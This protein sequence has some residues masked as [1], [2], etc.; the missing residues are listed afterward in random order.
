MPNYANPVRYARIVPKSHAALAV[1]PLTRPVDLVKLRNAQRREVRE[2]R[3]RIV[4]SRPLG[5]RMRRQGAPSLSPSTTGL[6]HWWTYEGRPI[7]GIGQ[8]LVNVTN[9]NLLITADDLDVPEGGGLDLA[10]RRVYNS[11]SQHDNNND[12]NSTPSV[13]GNKWT[14]N[15]DAHLGWSQIDQNDGTVSVYTGDGGRED[16]TCAINTGAVCTAETP[17]VQDLLAGT[18]LTGGVDCQFQ[19]TKKSG[20]SYIFTAPYQACGKL[21][22][23]YGRLVQIWGRNIAFY[24][25]L[26]YSWSPDA[27][28]PENLH[29]IV[30]TNQASGAQLFLNFGKIANTGITELMSIERPDQTYIDYRYNGTG[31][32]TGVDKPDSDPVLPVSETLPTQWPDGTPIPGGNLPE[33]YDVAQEGLLEA[34]GPRAAIGSLPPNGSPTDGACVDFDYVS[35]S[36]DLAD[37]WT[38]G[39]LNPSPEDDVSYSNIQSGPNTGFAQWD[40]TTFFSND[41]GTACNPLSEAGVSDADKHAISWCYDSSGRVIETAAAVST[42]S[43]LYTSQSWDTNNNLTSETDARGNTTNIA[44]DPNGNAVEIALPQQ[45]V[46]PPGQP[47]RP[48]YLLDYDQHN[49]LTYYCDPANNASNGWNPS[50]SDTL[51]ENSG[52]QSY[53]SYQYY[54]RDISEAYS[55]LLTVTTPRNYHWQYAYAGGAGVCGIGL[56]TTITGDTISQDNGRTPEQSFSYYTSGVSTGL[57]ETFSSTGSPSNASKVSY[58]GNNMNRVRSIQDP[59]GV[60]SYACYNPNGSVFYTETAYQNSLD[61]QNGCPTVN[62]IAGGATPPPFAVGYGYD[63]DGDVATVLRHHGC[64]A[65]NGSNATCT[66]SSPAPSNCY[67]MAVT[68]QTGT[69]CN[70]YDGLGRLVE[71]KQPYDPSDVYK[72]PWITRYLYD[73]S[74]G[75]TQNVFGQTFSAHGNLFEVQE[76]LPAAPTATAPPSPGSVA[77]PDNQPIKAWAYDGLD[78]PVALYAGMASPS[79]GY[80]TETLTWDNTPINSDDVAG[81]LGEDC[82]SASPQQCQEFDYTPDGQLQTFISSD[83]SSPKRVYTYDGDG[84]PTQITSGA[85]SNPQQYAYGPDG[86]IA[87]STDASNGVASQNSATLTYHRY[88]DGKEQSLDVASG[89]FTQAGL[90]GYSYQTDGL[91]KSEAVNDS[92]LG[93]NVKHPGTTTVSYTYTPAGRFSGRSESGADAPNPAPT[94]SVSYLPN[95]GLVKQVNY[96]QTTLTQFTFSVEGE[97]LNLSDS[98]CQEGSIA[99]WYTVRGE[100]SASHLCSTSGGSWF[101]NGLALH[102]PAT[103]AQVTWDNLMAV[104]IGTSSNSQS[105]NSLK[106]TWNYGSD[107]RLK[108]Q[109]APYP[110]WSPPGSVTTTRT[111]DAE[112]H[113]NQTT[114]ESPAPTSNVWPYQQMTWGPDGHPATIGTSQNG[115]PVMNERLHWSGGQL[116]FTVHSGTLDDV[117]VGAQGDILPGDAYSGLT[118]YDRGPGGMVLGCH[119]FTGTSYVGFSGGDW[120]GLGVSPCSKGLNPPSGTKMPAST[121]WAGSPYSAFNAQGPAL[122]AGGTLG[123]L[124]TDGFTDGYDTIQGVRALDSMT[125]LWMTPDADGGDIDD[126]A[127]LKSY[128]WSGNDPLGYVDPSGN[129][130]LYVGVSEVTAGQYHAYGVV[131][132]D[133]A[134]VIAVLSFGPS[135]EFL[136][137]NFNPG[138]YYEMATSQNGANLLEEAQC[139]GTCSWEPGLLSSYRNWPNNLYIYKLP[140]PD[141]NWALTKIFKE[142]GI[143]TTL[144]PGHPSL[145]GWG[146]MQFSYLPGVQTCS[147]VGGPNA[148]CVNFPAEV[149]PAGADTV[150]SSSLDNL[151]SSI[152]GGGNPINV[153]LSCNDAWACMMSY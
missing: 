91:L 134:N 110:I 136:N 27:S 19:W 73:L 33:T 65:T 105:T 113:L 121:L 13:F 95:L 59:D 141:S 138:V 22:G 104:L 84:R 92:S 153:P 17:G 123:T 39:V 125:G 124:R 5:R 1:E 16:F 112:N 60:T 50:Q 132:D 120:L 151:M 139:S 72:S 90:F 83:G 152:Y 77:N 126:P 40:D 146:W 122:G 8:A 14:N 32:L 127:S 29:Q 97:L 46:T 106:S 78:R 79:P 88:P 69:T 103:G 20:V 99:Y 51:C 52:S 140:S 26:S 117:K 21:P 135:G 82:N 137:N 131:T 25:T 94:A 37:W 102:P 23:A 147:S 128:L 150:V 56:P 43:T 86:N 68:V 18:S 45:S 149:V 108:S 6:W 101:A 67:H 148:G 11:Q 47:L 116:L 36:N 133:D 7:P 58:T 61:P 145:P 54:S 55:C 115:N 28:S 4:A 143:P 49:N 130:A 118:S 87:T 35:N 2:L 98:G 81:F 48:T 31:G 100:L 93:T 34:C 41:E 71:V 44:Y 85:F 109:A 76:R 62:M 64:W 3:P 74:Q 114:F 30:V 24:Q 12:D 142:N 107:G 57:L 89:P 53:T 10:F 129:D 96:P 70:F 80:T 66:A 111:Y 119:N 42:T 38:R 63:P 144:P 15:F 9:L 75:G